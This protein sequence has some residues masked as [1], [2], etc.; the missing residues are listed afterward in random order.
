MAIHIM[1]RHQTEATVTEKTRKERA[2]YWF[3]GSM[4]LIIVMG[5]NWIFGVL[6]LHKYLLPLIYLFAISTAVQGVWIFLLLVIGSKQVR[7]DYRKWL[8][9][10][11]MKLFKLKTSSTSSYTF[12]HNSN[13]KISGSNGNYKKS[14]ASA[15]N[16]MYQMNDM[17]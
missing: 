10:V 1:R 11:R 2:W 8:R 14:N 9:T 16:N 5:I 17:S 15:K 3:R 12:H 7:D 4:S 13:E 6:L